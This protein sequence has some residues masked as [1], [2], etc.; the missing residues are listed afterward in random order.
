MPPYIH[1]GKYYRYL[2]EDTN[3]LVI[4][5]DFAEVAVSKKLYEERHKIEPLSNEAEKLLNRLM[6]SCALAAVSLADRESWG[7]TVSLPGS[8][9]GMFCAVEPEGVITASARPSPIDR[10]AIYVQRQ[11]GTAP[12]TQSLLTPLSADPCEVVSLY[13]NQ[14]VQT[15]TR[16]VLEEDCSGILVQALP[17]SRFEDVENLANNE[18][19]KLCRGLASKKELK[20]MGE[21]LIFYEC[22]CDDQ[23]IL[24]MLTGLPDSEREEVWGD[25]N[26]LNIECPRCRREYEIQRS[27]KSVN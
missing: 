6:G 22:R 3:L 14:A 21:V 27:L 20:P 17:D 25:L 16:I 5:G 12:M 23:M 15:K 8:D 1:V 26:S 7:W 10:E 19:S 13:F 24:N 4:L 9:I 2:W 11:K 18:L